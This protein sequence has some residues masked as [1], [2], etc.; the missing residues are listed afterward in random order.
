MLVSTKMTLMGWSVGG[1]PSAFWVFGL[2]G[3]VWFPIWGLLAYEKPED[4]PNMH[5]N[6]LAIIR[7]GILLL[8]FVVL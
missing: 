1:W 5:P 2:V 4:H 3:V 6:E 8:F 7:E